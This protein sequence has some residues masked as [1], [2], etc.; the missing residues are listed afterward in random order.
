M[1]EAEREAERQ[2]YEKWETM[3]IYLG[4]DVDCEKVDQR[5]KAA[6]ANRDEMLSFQKTATTRE[7]AKFFKEEANEYLK[8]YRGCCI[9]L[10]YVMS[11]PPKDSPHREHKDWPYELLSYIRRACYD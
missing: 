1:T 9:V 8:E 10:G 7:F 3:V 11:D 4:Q 5:R 6:I 2:H